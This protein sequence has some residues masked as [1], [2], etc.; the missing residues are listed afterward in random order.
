M[1]PVFFV[2]KT[3]I[4][5]V[6][7]EDTESTKEVKNATLEQKVLIPRGRSPSTM[8]KDADL[9]TDLPT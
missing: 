8:L 5:F 4:S 9:R 3:A 7:T 6:T 1:N 2:V